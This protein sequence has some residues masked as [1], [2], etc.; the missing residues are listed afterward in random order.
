MNEAHR[1]RKTEHKYKYFSKVLS[2]LKST[3]K[4]KKSTTLLI[5]GFIYTSTSNHAMMFIPAI[6][7]DLGKR[8]TWK[9]L[10]PSCVS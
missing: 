8:Q 4:N 10:R 3:I 2:L 9:K 1:S 7:M 6:K 5:H